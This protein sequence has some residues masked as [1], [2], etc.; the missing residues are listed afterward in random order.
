[1]TNED[2]GTVPAKQAREPAHPAEE[3][4]PPAGAGQS[5]L[6]AIAWPSSIFVI[7]ERPLMPRSLARS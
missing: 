5:C 6:R 4:A 2:P 7:D 1:M 3:R